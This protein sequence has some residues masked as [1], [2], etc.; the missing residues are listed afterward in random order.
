MN[1]PHTAP[2]RVLCVFGCLDRGGAETMCM[3]LYRHIDRS[4]VQ[5][6]FVTHTPRPGAFDEEIRSLGGRIYI[7]PRF[8][9]WNLP[10]YFRWWRRHLKAHP[11]H[12]IVHGHYFSISGLYFR[13]AKKA[14][15][16]TVAHS[17]ATSL[18][19]GKKKL[20]DLFIALLNRYAD[21]RLAC[22]EAAGRFLFPGRD[23]TV[24]KNAVDAE[25]FAF[26]PAARAAVRRELGIP[27]AAPVAAVVGS[28]IPVKNPMGT[29]DIFR[30]LHEKR[31]DA[32]LLWC[33]G[34]DMRAEIEQR[35]SALGLDA[36][37]V[38][39]GVR[40]DIP[41]VLQAADVYLMP[42]LREGLPVSAIEAQAAGLPCLLSEGISR[43]AAITARCRFLPLGDAGV[44]AAEIENA[45]SEGRHDSRRELAAAGYDVCATAE[46]LREYY[47]RILK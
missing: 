27:E 45:L 42:S 38:L 40:R 13:E 23:F 30:A 28:L 39:A 14:G 25:T 18:F 9:G 35:I 43:E 15:R 41:R 8:R 5:F 6:D 31:P 34:G 29:L 7:A 17:H 46:W 21:Y 1:E 20:E 24:L 16:V 32:R 22:S 37:V 19:P 36:A 26:D 12:R 3:N 10:Q 2:V 33:G 47:M 11:E 4:R 44:W